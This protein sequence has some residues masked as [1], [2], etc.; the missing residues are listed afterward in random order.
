M[1]LIKKGLHGPLKWGPGSHL[2]K[3]YTG[4]EITSVCFMRTHLAVK[5]LSLFSSGQEFIMSSE[6][7]C[8]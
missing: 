6:M 3:L 5:L 2:A 8:S 4:S 1:P 7:F